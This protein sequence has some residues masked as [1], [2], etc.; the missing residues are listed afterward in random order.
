[1]A[2]G[3]HF[4][5]WLPHLKALHRD[6]TSGRL[7]TEGVV[8]ERFDDQAPDGSVQVGGGKLHGHPVS[9]CL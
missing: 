5:L 2:C 7:H 8:L 1:M 4:Q 3:G 6:A 9:V